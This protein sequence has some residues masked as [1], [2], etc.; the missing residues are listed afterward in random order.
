MENKFNTIEFYKKKVAKA[1]FVLACVGILALILQGSMA[2]VTGQYASTPRIGF[3]IFI[4][5]GVCE[6]IGFV[7]I[8]NKLFAN[9][10]LILKN[11]E[12]LKWS[13]TIVTIINYACIINLMPSQMMWAVFPFFLITI[14]LFVD[15]KLVIGSS[16]AFLLV[17]IAF[18]ATH[19]VESLQATPIAEELPGRGAITILGIAAVLCCGYFL[20]HILA[21]VGQSLMDENTKKMEELISSVTKMT[22]K[23]SGATQNLVAITQEENASMEEIMSVSSDIINDINSLLG[24][25]GKS[26]ERLEKLKEK[27]RYI[28]DR[29]KQTKEVSDDLVNISGTNQ[30]ALNNVLE[31]STAIDSSTNHTLDVAKQLEGKVEEID[32]LLK[33]IEN[34]ADE[35][36]LLALNASIEA[37]RAGEEGRGFAVVAEQVKKLSE[38][39][40]L[41]LQNVN[42]VVQSF[43]Q[44]TKL[45][46]NLMDKNVRQ[47][48]EQNKVTGDTVG[49]IKN[50]I[51]KLQSSANEIEEVE[52]LTR[53]QNSHTEEVV[54]YNNEVMAGIEEQISHIEDITKLIEENRKAIEQ[55][56]VET[57]AINESVLNIKEMLD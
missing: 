8:Y 54:D 2:L 45:V 6:A 26:K 50:M 41:S 53:E 49:I 18:F 25:T 9:E 46:E 23:L 37:A 33:L 57:D 19:S 44:D 39:T 20:G 12:I 32:N 15:F 34:I 16:I 36:N 11:Y 10:E 28:A 35:T 14:S 43:K 48:E 4:A 21:N 1:Q 7:F 24:K 27:V 29:M 31:I 38:N 51:S 3:I 52:A 30:E 40:T 47:I 5:M 13:I 56:I 55:I 17:I 42:E 22:I